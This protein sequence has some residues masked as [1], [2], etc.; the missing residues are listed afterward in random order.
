[1]SSFETPGRNGR[2]DDDEA[3]SVAIPSRPWVMPMGL[4]TAILF[5]GV[6]FWQLNANRTRA[7]EAR[8]TDPAPDAQSAISMEGVPPAPDLFALVAAQEGAG[9][10]LSDTLVPPPTPPAPPAAD[11]QD[12]LRSPSLVIDLS[13]PGVASTGQPM[14]PGAPQ[15]GA[16]HAPLTTPANRRGNR[17]R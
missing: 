6:V 7:D 2:H 8:F 12:R 4:A 17:S 1:M 10:Q 3:L 13:Q 14:A 9:G 15:S 11:M 16:A 5:G